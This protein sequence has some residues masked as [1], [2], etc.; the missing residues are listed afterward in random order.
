MRPVTRQFQGSKSSG[1]YLC[2]A[3]L[4]GDTGHHGARSTS[5]V[6]TGFAS[7]RLRNWIT[8]P[9]I[10]RGYHRPDNRLSEGE[11]LRDSQ[12][13]YGQAMLDHLRGREAWE[14]GERDD[15]YV[16]NE[17]VLCRR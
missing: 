12:D 14:I 7:C 6:S 8:W 13:A 9:V 1:R 2:S 16:S 17:F 11:W 10:P 5:P 4:S 15:G 3:T